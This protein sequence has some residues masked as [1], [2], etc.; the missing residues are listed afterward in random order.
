MRTWGG[1]K[2]DAH[3]LLNECVVVDLDVDVDGSVWEGIKDI[4][5]EWDTFVLTALAETLWPDK[6]TQSDSTRTQNC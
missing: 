6:R 2:K 4:P 3:N 1:K 5:E